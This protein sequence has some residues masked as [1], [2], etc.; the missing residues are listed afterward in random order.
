MPIKIIKID[1][2]V[3]NI[4]SAQHRAGKSPDGR[5][6][7][8]TLMTLHG[9]VCADVVVDGVNER[10]E[11]PLNDAITPFGMGKAK[12]YSKNGIAH[13]I[14]DYRTVDTFPVKITVQNIH[15]IS[16]IK[17]TADIDIKKRD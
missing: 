16:G 11:I 2:P 15:Q 5:K 12:D 10:I 1:H 17:W 9:D 14:R 6:E 8:R 3:L 13:I 4:T 7:Y